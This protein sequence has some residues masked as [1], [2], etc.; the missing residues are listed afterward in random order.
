[1][2]ASLLFQ[3]GTQMTMQLPKSVV[4]RDIMVTRLV[5][6]S[7]DKD[8]FDGIQTLVKNKISGAPVVNSDGDFV[9]IFSEKSAMRVLIDG[10]YDQ[11]PTSEVC[12][13][14]HTDPCTIT[15]DTALFSIAQIFTSTS[16]RRLPVL[17]DGKL[18][19]Q[20]SRRDVMKAV[21]ELIR[22]VPNN[23][24]TFLYLS[25]L[26]NMDDPPVEHF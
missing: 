9:G 20:V 5:T 16:H 19:G 21:L 7:P 8:V 4:A 18:V 10:A 15:E 13:F 3:K 2:V 23:S 1:M 14:M 26:R 24:N 6:L 11:F 17:R 25:A 12:S 22:N